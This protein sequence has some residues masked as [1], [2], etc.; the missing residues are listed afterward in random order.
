M[1]DKILMIN[2]ILGKFSRLPNVRSVAI[3]GSGVNS[4]S[5]SLSDID[6]YVFTEKDI[7][8]QQRENIIKEYSSEYEAGGEYFGPGD[9]FFVDKLNQQI[10]M[11]YWNTGWF[12]SSVEN[13]WHKHYP[14]NGYTTAFIF[15]LKNA[16]IFS[17]TDNWLADMKKTVR[18]E[19]PGE[20]K[21]NIIK[22]NMMLMK[23]KPFASYYEQTEKALERGD[24]V[25]IN[26]RTAAF[27]AS[28]FDVLFAV[29]ELLHPG[30]K[31]LVRYAKDNCRLL[32]ADFEEN[33]NR[34]L[35]LHDSEILTVM[36]KMYTALQNICS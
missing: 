8:V 5:D 7:P 26:H 34:L 25:S 22:R 28:Y 3:G 32:P 29:N 4:T 16:E 20:L 31:R 9:E 1:T 35:S 12:E 6:V 36:N 13:V 30:E 14:S 17:D 10:D 18:T 15:T 27:L 23:G 24:I 2:S 33:I 21:A 19:Y 11:M